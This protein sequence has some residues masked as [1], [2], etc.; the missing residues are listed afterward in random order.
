M[1]VSCS[2][3]RE[4]EEVHKGFRRADLMEKDNLEDLSIGG[5]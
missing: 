1:G 2:T 3:H 4:T 5:M